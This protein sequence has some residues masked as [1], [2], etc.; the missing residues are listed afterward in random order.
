MKS[1]KRKERKK[2]KQ[3]KNCD[4]QNW[5]VEL[6]SGVRLV[7]LMMGNTKQNLK[8]SYTEARGSEEI[9]LWAKTKTWNKKS[10][11]CFVMCDT[12]HTFKI[13]CREERDA[14]VVWQSF[15]STFT[16]SSLC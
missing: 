3:K 15:S 2:M 11:R 16:V 9:N 5:H 14:F 6:D 12:L 13:Q 4:R 10:R 7:N 8:N 1:A